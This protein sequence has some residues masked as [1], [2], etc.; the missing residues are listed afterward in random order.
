MSKEISG[1]WKENRGMSKEN[2]GMWKENE[3][4]VRRPRGMGKVFYE[5]RGWGLEVGGQGLG[6]RG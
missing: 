6:V 3:E 5:V 4:Q 2:N 1:M